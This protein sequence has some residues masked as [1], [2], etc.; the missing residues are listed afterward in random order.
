MHACGGGGCN[1]GEDL[2][3][4]SL[5]VGTYLGDPDQRTD[6]MV[7]NAVIYS[8]MNGW[9]VID[10]GIAPQWLCRERC[11]PAAK[12]ARGDAAALRAAGTQCNE[13]PTLMLRTRALSINSRDWLAPCQASKGFAGARL[14]RQAAA[15]A[16]WH[17]CTAMLL[18]HARERRAL[19][20]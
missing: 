16:S 15:P 7:T 10:T 17:V 18:R 6:D 8:V 14:Q 20:P 5:G 3:L 4:S 19:M 12:Q 11:W 2:T 13:P 1:A 9:N